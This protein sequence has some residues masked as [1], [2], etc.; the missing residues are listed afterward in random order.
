MTNEEK[1]R[2]FEDQMFK[3]KWAKHLKLSPLVYC[4]SKEVGKAPAC[5]T[6]GP[7]KEVQVVVD[8]KKKKK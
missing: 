2:L 4:L 1:Q 3:K 5:N 6:R 8:N 7:K